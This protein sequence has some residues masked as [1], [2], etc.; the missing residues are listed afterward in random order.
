[1]KTTKFAPVLLALFLASL[2]PAI[3]QQITDKKKQEEDSKKKKEQVTIIVDTEKEVQK[4][5]QKDLQKAM[6]ESLEAGERALKAKKLN[7]YMDN[8]SKEFFRQAEAL[9]DSKRK[10]EEMRSTGENWEAHTLYGNPT[11]TWPGGRWQGGEQD[12]INVY[13]FNGNRENT[14]LS[15]SKTLEDVTFSTDFYYDVKNGSS[16][17]SFFVNG[18]LK[19]GELKITLKKPDKTAF[20]E[21]TISPLADVNWNQ[22]FRWDEEVT[23]EYLGKWTISITAAKANGNYR[24]QVNSR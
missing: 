20:Q 23:D 2:M 7:G 9:Q 21:I 13:S 11:L 17:I 12:A 16:N 3:G 22:Q 24:V 4:E 5:V 15:I 19:A 1:M 18:T 14:S 6:A 8:L 10:L